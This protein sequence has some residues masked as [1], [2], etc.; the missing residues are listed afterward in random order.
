MAK[1]FISEMNEGMSVETVF[2]CNHKALL[3]DKNGKPYL[4]VQ[5][6]DR[7]G[8][9]EARIWERA[10]Q[11]NQNFGK[12]DYVRVKGNVVTFQGHLQFNI[13]DIQT[14]TTDSVQQ[15]DFL[16]HTTRNIDEM[17]QELLEI[18][19]TSLQNSYVKNLLLSILEDEEM[20]PL[21]K[22]APAA[23]SNH[24]AWIGG[25]LE[26][27]LQLVKVGQSVLPHYPMVNGD[28]V[29]AGLILH[30]F[31]KIYE[32]RSERAL[33]Y[34]DRGQLVGHLVISVEILIQKAAA[35]E[36]FPKKILH[37][38]E[39]ILLSHHGLLEY[40]S[41]K[42]PMTMEALMVHHLDNMDSKLQGFLDVVAREKESESAWTGS[43]FLFK[44]PLYKKTQ[45]D[46]GAEAEP[47]KVA[48]PKAKPHPARVETAGEEKKLPKKP[49]QEKRPHS[50]QPLK[51]N[52]GSLLAEN[53]QKK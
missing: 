35:Q 52:L 32:L 26:H 49:V 12:F 24:H 10:L 14:V 16:P 41:P 39:H 13:Q 48:T 22:R 2:L 8:F 46:M 47:A 17:Y 37:H 3:K 19:R 28:L 43:G 23:K 27:V 21:F 33:D 45:A 9:I 15:D 53:F 44:R 31:G 50:S 4:N 36:N 11:F 40:G 38:I 34:T 1:T 51:T 42:E 29:I 7:S 25:L 30:D 6:A 20:A 18:C 5:L